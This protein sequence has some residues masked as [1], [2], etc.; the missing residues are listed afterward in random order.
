ML[1][2]NVYNL[3]ICVVA[4]VL[5]VAVNANQIAVSHLR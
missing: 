4:A 1:I 2:F 5:Y 3:I